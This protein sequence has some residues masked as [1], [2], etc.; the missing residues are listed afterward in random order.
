MILYNRIKGFPSQY[1]LVTVFECFA[2]FKDKL[3]DAPVSTWNCTNTAHT[4][5]CSELKILSATLGKQCTCVDGGSLL[6]VLHEAW[7]CTIVIIGYLPAASR[8]TKAVCGRCAHCEA[9][10][11]CNCRTLRLLC[12]WSQACVPST[13]SMLS[14]QVNPRAYVQMKLLDCTVLHALVQ[15]VWG[16][17]H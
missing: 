12:Y 13:T 10:W 14:H 7:C 15:T 5:S 11:Q 16:N 4:I 17:G 3:S 2:L 6:V 8:L 9:R 1:S